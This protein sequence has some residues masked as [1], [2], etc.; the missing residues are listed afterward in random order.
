MYDCNPSQSPRTDGEPSSKKAK[1][2]IGVEDMNDKV[3]ID[4]LK[5]TT[6]LEGKPVAK[7]N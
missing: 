2:V 1:I 6:Q 4:D 3:T 7:Y 5:S